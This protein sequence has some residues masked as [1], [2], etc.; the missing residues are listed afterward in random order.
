M[1]CHP[2]VRP[3]A[4]GGPTLCAEQLTLDARLR[5]HERG[6]ACP[7]RC[8]HSSNRHASSHVLFEASGAPFAFFARTPE[9]I[10]GARDAGVPPCRGL[11]RAH[12]VC[13]L[14]LRP[15]W[16]AAAV[17]LERKEQAPAPAVLARDD[18]H[19]FLRRMFSGIGFRNRRCSV[20]VPTPPNKPWLAAG[21]VSTPR[22][23]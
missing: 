14:P 11:S 7:L 8:I 23:G 3:R 21:R 10:E 12:R 6:R 20:P 15:R 17:A 2:S 22:R 19:E 18:K 9:K 1:D 16:R 5:G 13:C 4:C